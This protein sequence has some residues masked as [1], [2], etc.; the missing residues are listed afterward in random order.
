MTAME[1]FKLIKE[2]AAWITV[3]AAAI[4]IFVKPVREKIFKQKKDN[5]AEREG[6][7]CLLRTDL[8]KIY[9]KGRDTQELEQY[10]AENFMKLYESYKNLGGNSFIDE[11][12][13]HV[14]RWKIK[15]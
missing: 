7:K 9:Y 1:V 3:V 12:Y 4:V 8:L 13:E 11:I 10:E 5:Q 14:T 6:L 15:H 2:I